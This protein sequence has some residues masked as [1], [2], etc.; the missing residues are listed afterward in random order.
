[1]VLR[2]LDR[3]HRLWP[4]SEGP[5][6]CLVS[7]AGAVKFTASPPFIP[8]HLCPPSSQASHYCPQG[9]RGCWSDWSS[10][11]T[12]IYLWAGHCTSGSQAAALLPL[13]AE[14]LEEDRD[15]IFSLWPRL[16]PVWWGRCPLCLPL[17]FDSLPPCRR[18]GR[19]RPPHQEWSFWGLSLRCDPAQLQPSSSP[20]V[21]GASLGGGQW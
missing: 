18:P 11:R 9:K 19:G 4:W 8:A 3:G 15:H 12:L 20:G 2:W 7:L 21:S 5:G 17:S 1:M 10:A 14:S 13:Q 16:H 6:L